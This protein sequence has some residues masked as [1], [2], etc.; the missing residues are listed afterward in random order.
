MN[1]NYKKERFIRLAEKRV[2]NAVK[3]LSLIANLANTSNY[4]FNS[5]QI[6]TMMNVLD[7]EFKDLKTIF[8]RKLNKKKT[9][10]LDE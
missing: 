8:N 10:K 5:K 4:E 7:R 1:T 9:F 6:K 2:N 3:A